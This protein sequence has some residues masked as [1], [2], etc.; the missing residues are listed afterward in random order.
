MR[1][2]QIIEALN[3]KPHPTE[4]GYFRRTYES[5]NSLQ[6]GKEQRL[7]L[8]TIYYMLTV[9]SSHGYMHKNESDIVHF[10]HSGGPIRYWIISPDGE[11]TEKILG[12]D[13]TEGVS[14]Q[15]IVRGGNWKI[16]QLLSG[17]YGLIGE[18]VAPGFEY[19]D[20]TMA[21]REKIN[22]LFPHLLERLRPYVKHQ[23]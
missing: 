22:E 6:S 12:Q 4:G 2:K 23:Q 16:S 3:L 21:T 10:H 14:P 7:L 20:N 15:L 9:D 18:A 19:R 1:K 11:F 8:T 17:E 5:D 13:I